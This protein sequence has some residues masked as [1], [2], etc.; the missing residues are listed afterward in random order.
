MK[1]GKKKCPDCDATMII[2]S[3]SVSVEC[4]DI[5]LDFPTC[6][7]CGYVEYDTNY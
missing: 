4:Q 5:E 6:K 2:E 7:E 1:T 3:H